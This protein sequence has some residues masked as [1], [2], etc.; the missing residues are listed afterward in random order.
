MLAVEYPTEVVNGMLR[1]LYKRE[2]ENVE[3]EEF[4]SGVKTVLLYDS[5]FEE[6]DSLFR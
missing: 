4:L 6:M 1:Q 3:F 5:Y 2:E